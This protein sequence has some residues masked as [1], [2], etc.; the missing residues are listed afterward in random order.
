MKATFVKGSYY[1]RERDR[2][3]FRYLGKGDIVIIKTGNIWL[4]DK[5]TYKIQTIVYSDF[6]HIPK[7][8]YELIKHNL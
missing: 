2:T 5:R 3:L 4:K 7:I 1:Y 8:R 6:E